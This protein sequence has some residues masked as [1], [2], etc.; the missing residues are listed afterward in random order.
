MEIRNA[1]LP[2]PNVGPPKLPLV[3]PAMYTL[4][5][6]V[7]AVIARALSKPGVP[8]CVDHSTLPLAASMASTPGRGRID[9][10]NGR[11]TSIGQDVISNADLNIYLFLN[12]PL[13]DAFVASR[14]QQ[15]PG[16]PRAQSAHRRLVERLA[17]RRQ[18]HAP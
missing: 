10:G 7:S 9:E 17:L 15:Q 18:Q 12:Y 13:V 11:D 1:S 6:I 4:P 16:P 3:S 2:P 14:D 8:I 5:R